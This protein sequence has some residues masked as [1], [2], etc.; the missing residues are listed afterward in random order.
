MERRGLEGFGAPSP[1]ARRRER[2]ARKEESPRRRCGVAA[3]SSTSVMSM[4]TSESWWRGEE[5]P[6]SDLSGDGGSE[7][8]GV[9]PALGV[10]RLLLLG[11]ATLRAGEPVERG[12]REG[13]RSLD[14]VGDGSL[15]TGFDGGR[16]PLP[17]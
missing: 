3:S 2:P 4:D 12:I 8:A 6:A 17:R 15:D 5:R 10:S 14:G 7:D 13:R 11:A 16:N 9:G 1:R